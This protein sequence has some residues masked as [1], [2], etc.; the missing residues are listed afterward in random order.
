MVTLKKDTYK[1]E[2]TYITLFYSN[3]FLKVTILINSNSKHYHSKHY[4]NTFHI[5]KVIKLKSILTNLKIPSTVFLLIP[6][7]NIKKSILT[8][9]KIPSTVFL[10][11]FFSN[12]KKSILANL[13]I[14][15]FILIIIILKENN[16]HK[17]QCTN[18][19]YKNH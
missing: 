10:L 17:N 5:K 2:N 9:L 12:I 15:L 1:S 6:F 4:H 11:I 16:L 13:K 19:S 14:L 18:N 7:L 3:N 8:N